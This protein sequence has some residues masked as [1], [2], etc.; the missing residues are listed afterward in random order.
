MAEKHK[1]NKPAE[2]RGAKGAKP[3][4]HHPLPKNLGKR[5]TLNKTSKATANPT[6]V[7]SR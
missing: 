5:L 6:P 4:P 3:L 1:N 2:G 7:H